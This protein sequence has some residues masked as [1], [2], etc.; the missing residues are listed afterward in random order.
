[1][2]DVIVPYLFRFSSL[3]VLNLNGVAQSDGSMLDAFTRNRT[4]PEEHLAN[5]GA[6]F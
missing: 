1:M 3:D 5:P 4:D 6:N 2:G